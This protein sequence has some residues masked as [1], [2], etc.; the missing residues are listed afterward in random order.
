MIDKCRCL[1]FLEGFDYPKTLSVSYINKS[2]LYLDASAVA[3]L[4]IH[5]RIAHL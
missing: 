2:R 5:P 1:A 3:T 4:T